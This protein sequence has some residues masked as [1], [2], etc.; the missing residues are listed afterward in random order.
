MAS[1][2]QS[3][4]VVLLTVSYETVS[5]WAVRIRSKRAVYTRW[6]V[7]VAKIAAHKAHHFTAQPVPNSCHR[8][9]LLVMGEGSFSS[10]VADPGVRQLRFLEQ[11]RRGV[12]LGVLFGVSMDGQ[13]VWRTQ[14][15][16]SG[17]PQ[18]SLISLQSSSQSNVLQAFQAVTV[19][20]ITP[21]VIQ[22]VPINTFQTIL[23]HE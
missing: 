15:M 23:F 10:G 11:Q 19:T 1:K 18:L 8:L 14:Q 4:S 12:E 9:W 2:R 21:I 22:F 20:A 17:L 3:R 16:L 7:G 5:F 6:K 13:L